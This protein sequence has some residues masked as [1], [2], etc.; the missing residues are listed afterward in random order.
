MQKSDNYQ[1]NTAI[2]RR[3]AKAMLKYLKK[4]SSLLRI[5]ERLFSVVTP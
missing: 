2:L 4:K 1:T 3:V 5:A